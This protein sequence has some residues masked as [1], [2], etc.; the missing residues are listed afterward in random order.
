MKKLCIHISSRLSSERWGTRVKWSIISNSSYISTLCPL[1]LY[2]VGLCSSAGWWSGSPA[3]S[4]SAS[5][6]VLVIMLCWE[7][8]NEQL[9]KCFVRNIG[10]LYSALE[11]RL[12][13]ELGTLL[14]FWFCFS[15]EE[16]MNMMNGLQSVVH[17]CYKLILSP[18]WPEQRRWRC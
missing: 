6:S 13:V 9:F 16:G 12:S 7:S 4:G 2:F 17:N 15:W 5:L 11:M 18:V 14:C 10:I 3:D 8:G 1:H